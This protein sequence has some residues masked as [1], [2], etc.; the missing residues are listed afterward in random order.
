MTAVHATWVKS[1]VSL[2]K[3]VSTKPYKRYKNKL[4]ASLVFCIAQVSKKDLNALWSLITFYGGKVKLNLDS[5]CTHLICGAPKGARY[6]TA[7]SL[8]SEKLSVITP[9]W[10]IDSINVNSLCSTSVYHP[11]LLIMDNG[12]TKNDTKNSLRSITGFDFEESIAKTEVP[13]QGPKETEQSKD[14]FDN[15]R[16]KLPW[17][18][19]EPLQSVPSQSPLIKSPTSQGFTVINS[20]ANVALNNNANVKFS[21]P[22]VN[23][24]HQRLQQQQIHN[25]QPMLA[26][27]QSMAKQNLNQ[28]KI[29][30]MQSSPMHNQQNDEADWK[31]KV[32]SQNMNNKVMSTAQQII[33]STGQNQ[34]QI[35]NMQ[36]MH[37][38]L[39]LNINIGNQMAVTQSG[40]QII[41]QNVTQAGLNQQQNL[42]GNQQIINK[43]QQL[44]NQQLANQHLINNSQ[45]NQNLNLNNQQIND[46]QNQQ[47]LIQQQNKVMNNQLQINNQQIQLSQHNSIHQI[48][49]QHIITTSQQPN[50]QLNSS[51]I[52][53]QQTINQQQII[54]QQQQPQQIF[55][56]QTTIQNQQLINQQGMQNPQLINMQQ[57]QQIINQQ[58]LNPN[59][60]INNQRVESQ[61]LNQ[62]NI[63]ILGQQQ[64]NVQNQQM[65]QQQNQQVI[66]QQQN[67]Q[68][69]I[70]KKQKKNQ[71]CLTAIV[72]IQNINLINFYNLSA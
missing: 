3:L 22:N 38:K 13:T 61:V 29:Q 14:G 49:N 62:Q 35:N 20:Q 57:N 15:S 30:S 69:S 7:M 55:K 50:Q 23:N 56:S 64:Q 54:N 72:L 10:I 59:S 5:K 27:Q 19:S 8:N 12:T 31:T 60:L 45:L 67:P 41:T 63:Q 17:N 18:V 36:Q 68:V 33:V 40:G 39:E 9:D 51:P 32:A 16:Q 28:Q 47:M 70:K 21:Q 66:N 4:F 53:Q 46:M 34:L 58:M 52:N 1:C 65:L 11:R 6:T 25:S 44:S 37:Q 2:N 42:V 48:N 24:Q 71:F 26:N 43:Q